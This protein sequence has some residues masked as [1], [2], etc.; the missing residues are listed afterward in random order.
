MWQRYLQSVCNKV[1]LLH[2]YFVRAARVIHAY[3]CYFGGHSINVTG[4]VCNLEN[5]KCH[6][7][8]EST[9]AEIEVV[10]DAQLAST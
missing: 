1:S 3:L 2:K 8:D 10:F 4:G 7:C 9:I 5:L 6:A